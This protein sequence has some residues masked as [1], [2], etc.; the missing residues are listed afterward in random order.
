MHT[1]TDTDT[2]ADTDTD[3]DTRTHKHHTSSKLQYLFRH[4]VWPG[5]KTI[6]TKPKI[7]RKCGQKLGANLEE[8][9]RVS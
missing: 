7:K 3:T 1:D 6:E 8:I 2:D 9:W 5:I 4:A